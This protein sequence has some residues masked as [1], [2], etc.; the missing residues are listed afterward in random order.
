MPRACSFLGASCSAQVVR[1]K[2]LHLGPGSKAWSTE[3]VTVSGPG[4]KLFAAG[5]IQSRD[6]GLMGLNLEAR[7]G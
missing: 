1:L 2:T 4:Q 5:C 6:Q 3:S 7:E